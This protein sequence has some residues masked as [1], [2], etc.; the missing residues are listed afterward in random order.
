MKFEYNI[1]FLTEIY[2]FFFR[3]PRRKLHEP[4]LSVKS[5]KPKPAS[6]PVEDSKTTKPEIIED[7]NG[8]CTNIVF[9]IDFFHI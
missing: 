9:L 8:Q 5:S 7:E 2:N 1:Q 6:Q 4:V 3:Q